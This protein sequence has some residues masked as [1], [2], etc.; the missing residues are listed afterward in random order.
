MAASAGDAGGVEGASDEAM[1]SG[2]GRA[3]PA[4]AGGTGD[5]GTGDAAATWASDKDGKGAS[6]S[7]ARRDGV[8]AAPRAGDGGSKVVALA[9][10]DDRG[11]ADSDD[12]DAECGRVG[13]AAV[14]AVV[15]MAS[16][17]LVGAAAVSPAW[18]ASEGTEDDEASEGG[19]APTD[20]PNDDV[21][22]EAPIAVATAGMVEAE[23]APTMPTGPP[24]PQVGEGPRTAGTQDAAGGTVGMAASAGRRVGGGVG[25]V[26]SGDDTRG[27]ALARGTCR[28]G[29]D[30]ALVPGETVRAALSGGVS[31]RNDTR[32][33]KAHAGPFIARKVPFPG[34]GPLG[35]SEASS[36]T[37]DGADGPRGNG[38]CPC[39]CCGVGLGDTACALR[40]RGCCGPGEGEVAQVGGATRGT[41]EE[42]R[43]V[44]AA[45]FGRAVLPPGVPGSA[46]PA[47]GTA[48]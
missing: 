10:G 46:G 5:E 17:V 34:R 40:G 1:G 6:A 3:P 45:S 44:E 39:C 26:D 41:G 27:S 36:G 19:I 22:E 28:G 13:V 21:D 32:V 16:E 20:D 15:V 8:A 47:R 9:H 23:V 38:D 37:G 43:P 2:D 33:S 25:E 4:R 35:N 31:D 7:A 18:A 30:V 14:V 11:D 24:I 29:A 48:V 42:R 12:D